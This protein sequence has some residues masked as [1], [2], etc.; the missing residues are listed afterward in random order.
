MPF[1]E[2][3]FS[4]SP[5]PQNDPHTTTVGASV[6]TEREQFTYHSDILKWISETKNKLPRATPLLRKEAFLADPMISGTIY[7]Y[8]KNV[9]LKDYKIITS[10]NKLY[11]EAIEEI[12]DYLEALKIMK[13]F[14]ED[15]LDYAFLVGHSYRR[16]DPDKQGNIASLGRLDPASMEVYEDPWDSSIIAYHQ[17][18]QVKTS[19]S[20]MSTTIDVDSWFIPFGQ[21]I[22]NIYDTWV[23]DRETGNN[24]KV[25]DLFDSYKTKYSIS[26]I[27][28]L[29]IGSSERIFAMHNAD[30]KYTQ[31]SDDDYRE[32]YS[33]AP[34]DSVLLAIW[35]KRLLLVNSPNLIYVVL[36]P[37]LHLISGVLKESKDALGNPVILSSNPRKPSTALQTT[38]AGQYAAEL[39]N[40]NAWIEAMQEASRGLIKSLKDG[41]VFTSGPDLAIKPIESARTVSFQL[42]QGLIANLNEEICLGLGLPI[43]LISAKGTEL[44]SSR[45]IVQTFNNIQ[46][47]KRTDYE[48]LADELIK[49]QFAGR[50]WMNGEGTYSFEDI[51]VRFLLE[52]LDTKDMKSEAETLK[53]K[54]ET[55]ANIKAIG[56]SQSD[57]QALGDEYGFGVLDLTNYE[58]QIN[59]LGPEQVQE[60][61]AILK[62]CLFGAMQE[63]GLLSA[64]PTDPSNFDETKLVKKLQEAYEEGMENIFEE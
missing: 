27:N 12:T 49:K 47:G 45:N 39:A 25:Y 55:L 40:F 62:A 28:N 59:P 5:T 2:F 30:V 41:G 22:Q 23:Q 16:A 4:A 37:F 15:F 52:T 24:L 14:R 31:T 38:N 58:A 36:S 17:K 20:L 1:P 34:I 26:D 64:K 44:A 60:V 50:T 56:G 13:V 53:L 29:R 42:I 9:L 57:V 35:L 61:N 8:L 33:P 48:A 43:A 63:G 7:P 18:A 6:A 51:K 19:W 54:A 10:D 21:D 46:I 11:S 3:F 32:V